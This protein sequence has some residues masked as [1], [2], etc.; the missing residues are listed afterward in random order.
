M[1]MPHLA[2]GAAACERGGSF[3]MAGNSPARDFPKGAKKNVD[4]RSGFLY[5]PQI[6]RGGILNA[7]PVFRPLRKFLT[8][9]NERL[10]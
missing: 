4:R 7:A 6:V 3:L 5:K 9:G 10:Y 2:T 8:S 1:R